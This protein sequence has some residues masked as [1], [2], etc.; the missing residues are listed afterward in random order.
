MKRFYFEVRDQSEVDRI[1]HKASSHNW[2]ISKLNKGNEFPFTIIG[3]LKEKCIETIYIRDYGDATFCST[4]DSFLNLIKQELPENW[5]IKFPKG[6]KDLIAYYASFGI[7]LSCQNSYYFSYLGKEFTA[8]DHNTSSMYGIPFNFKEITLAQFKAW[9][10]SQNN[11]LFPKKWFVF[12]PKGDEEFKEWYRLNISGAKDYEC[13]LND[14]Y[15]NCS[16]KNVPKEYA[17]GKGFV[18]I[19]LEQ[20]REHYLGT[21]TSINQMEYKIKKGDL[22]SLYKEVECSTVKRAI[23]SYLEHTKFEFESFEITLARQDVERFFS[24]GSKADIAKAE[25]L[26]LKKQDT[27]AILPCTDFK[28][29]EKLVDNLNEELFESLGLI[30]TKQLWEYMNVPNS[31]L[32]GRSLSVP[33]S[34]KVVLHTLKHNSGTIIEFQKV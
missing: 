24:Q 22:L 1:F 27:N 34:V 6:D 21:K 9:W 15:T 31:E 17:L 3:K 30:L 29:R 16:T 8:Y 26:G 32:R 13:D 33:S 18:E 7:N 5:Y 25:S 4:I 2:K 20:W 11:K 28:H 14:A 12:N 10:K 23:E 19:T